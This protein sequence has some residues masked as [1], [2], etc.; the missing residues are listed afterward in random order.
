MIEKFINIKNFKNSFKK[1]NKAKPFSYAICDNFLQKVII[2][3]L[4]NEFSDY[5]EKNCWHE[6]NNPIE[7]KKL[8]IIGTFLDQILI[9]LFTC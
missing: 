6:Y 9:N 8:V 5:Y 1:F 7:V 2:D 3:K 4:L